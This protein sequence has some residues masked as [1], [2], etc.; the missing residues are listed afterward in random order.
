[1]NQ[2][3]IISIFYYH[4]TEHFD[5]SSIFE[6]KCPYDICLNKTKNIPKN[7]LSFIGLMIFFLIK[8][9]YHKTVLFHYLHDLN[10]QPLFVIRESYW[11]ICTHDDSKMY[12]EFI[13]SIM[14]KIFP[15][16]SFILT[17]R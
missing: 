6:K 15:K 12:E 17:V 3:T 14:L 10:A 4:L 5:W 7:K 8:K 11:Y 13:E 16:N 9:G 2:L 1:M